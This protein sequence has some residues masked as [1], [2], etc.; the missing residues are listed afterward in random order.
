MVECIVYDGLI[1]IVTWLARSGMERAK[2]GRKN[3]TQH[4]DTRVV[5]VV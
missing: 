2:E 4:G 1:R 5:A 3:E